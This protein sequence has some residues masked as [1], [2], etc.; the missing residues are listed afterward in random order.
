MKWPVNADIRRKSTAATRSIPAQQ[1]AQ[2]AIASLMKRRTT[3]KT[4]RSGSKL[5]APLGV[6][7]LVGAPYLAIWH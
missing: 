1:L 5:P 7:L 4:K 2:N 6:G 3:M